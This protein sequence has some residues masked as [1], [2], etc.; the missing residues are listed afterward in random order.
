[1]MMMACIAG[2]MIG[3]DENIFDQEINIPLTVWDKMPEAWQ[4]PYKT[5]EVSSYTLALLDDFNKENFA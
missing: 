2:K 5:G 1:M 3:E 4:V